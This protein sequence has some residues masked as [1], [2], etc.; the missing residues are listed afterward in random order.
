MKRT[1]TLISFLL[2]LSLSKAVCQNPDSSK[3]RIMPGFLI[4]YDQ[5]SKINEE[6]YGS[7]RFNKKKFP[8]EL[9]IGLKHDANNTNFNDVKDLH[10]DTYSV[11]VDANFYLIK[12]FYAG[13]RLTM[14]FNNVDS[15]SQDIY[16]SVKSSDPPVFFSG[17]SFLG[18]IGYCQPIFKN[19]I[20]LRIQGQV[21]VRSYH[22]ANGSLYFSSS[23]IT[24]NTPS[25][26]E[27]VHT[28]SLY[29]ISLGLGYRI[30]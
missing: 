5:K 30:K 15:K 28:E 3:I 24:T 23:Y 22:I 4:G 11:L 10:F 8:I 21:G 18:Q 13:L 14:D 9:K 12:N 27:E 20:Y 7:I 1:I 26:R 16:Q 2:L 19:R 6:I 29:N 17:S 25:Y